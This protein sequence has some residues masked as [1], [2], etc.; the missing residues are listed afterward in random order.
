MGHLCLHLS[1]HWE[2]PM[3]PDPEI[4]IRHLSELL[5]DMRL[6]LASME[7]GS[8]CGLDN[9]AADTLRSRI[10]SRIANLE[11][12]IAM[13]EAEI[14]RESAPQTSWQLKRQ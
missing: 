9:P 4:M 7:G 10:L 1:S 3:E 12:E 14:E 11:A 8:H 6:A 2:M 5:K 13:F